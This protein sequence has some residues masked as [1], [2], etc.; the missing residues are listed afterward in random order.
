MVISSALGL[1]LLRR[2]R[3]ED[4]TPRARPTPMMPVLSAEDRALRRASDVKPAA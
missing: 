3:P 4:G 2:E 1:V